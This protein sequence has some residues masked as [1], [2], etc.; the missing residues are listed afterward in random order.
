MKIALHDSDGTG[1]PNLA[2]MKLSAH[3]K[4]AGDDVEWFSALNGGG[5][6]QGVLVQDIHMGAS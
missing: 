1:Y 6:R 4:A 5:V 2:L 3:H